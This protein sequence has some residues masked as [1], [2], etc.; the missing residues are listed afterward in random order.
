M[1]LGVFP[2]Q[3]RVLECMHIIFR[4]LCIHI[5]P[6]GFWK[7]SPLLEDRFSQD[8]TF[9]IYSHATGTKY[10]APEF[11][12]I[13]SSSLIGFLEMCSLIKMRTASAP[14]L[15]GEEKHHCSPVLSLKK[16]SFLTSSSSHNQF[17]RLISYNLEVSEDRRVVKPVS[18]SF[19]MLAKVRIDKL[20]DF[21]G[22]TE[23]TKNHM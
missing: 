2:S 3:E 12:S 10:C 1:L 23:T 16:I 15:D 21:C 22:N 9:R 14:H 18:H 8:F 5:C 6:N 17:P 13:L 7:H 4:K 11:Y 19:R 20:C